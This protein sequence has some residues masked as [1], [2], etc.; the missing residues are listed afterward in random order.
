MTVFCTF[1]WKERIMTEDEY[2]QLLE[3]LIKDALQE[4]IGDGDHSTLCCIPPTQMGKAVLKIKQAGVLA[5]VHVARTIF[6]QAGHKWCRRSN[7][8][9]VSETQLCHALQVHGIAT[10]NLSR[11]G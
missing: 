7:H 3:T 1:D 4:D 5:G 2:N 9:S 10:G 6:H 11:R 8:V